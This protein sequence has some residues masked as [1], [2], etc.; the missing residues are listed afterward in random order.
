CLD[1][2]R[3]GRESCCGAADDIGPDRQP[4]GRVLVPSLLIAED[5]DA[6]RS[7]L[8]KAFDD[9]GFAVSAVTNG[10]EAL[11]LDLGSLP[12]VILLDLNMP[13]MDGL[14]ATKLLKNNPLTKHIPIIAMTAMTHLINADS[15]LDFAAV[16]KKPFDIDDVIGIVLAVMVA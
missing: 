7:L 4:E 6:I 3:G 13:V 8:S 1:A 5:D 15:R 10:S 16:L 2:T 9:E 12:D 11:G 14:T